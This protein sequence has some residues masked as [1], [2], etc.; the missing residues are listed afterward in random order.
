MLNKKSFLKDSIFQLK[1][2]NNK[3]RTNIFSFDQNI[4]K[5]PTKIPI[6][7][8]KLGKLEKVNNYSLHIFFII[9]ERVI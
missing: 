3:K 7:E 6:D 4:K 8:G 9:H 1:N 5:I 2:E